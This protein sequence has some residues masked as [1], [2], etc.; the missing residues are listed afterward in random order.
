ME[1]GLNIPYVKAYD[2]N[3]VCTNPINGGY[4]SEFDNRKT[5]RAHM[6]EPDFRGNVSHISLTVNGISK[7]VRVRQRTPRTLITKHGKGVWIK[8]RTILH[9]LEQ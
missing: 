7:F 2:A 9:Y 3:G 8:P 6:N 4:F 5:R 1:R